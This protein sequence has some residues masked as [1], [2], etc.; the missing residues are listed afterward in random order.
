MARKKKTWTPKQGRWPS[1]AMASAYTAVTLRE[2]RHPRGKGIPS[3]LPATRPPV[4]SISDEDELVRHIKDLEIQGFC[5]GVQAV[6]KLAYEMA[7]HAGMKHRFR[8]TEAFG[9]S[10]WLVA[11]KARRSVSCKS[12]DAEPND[13]HRSFQQIRWCHGSCWSEVKPGSDI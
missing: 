8:G 6:C 10:S 2:T 7:E 4:F 5:T 1:D 13:H 3:S 9:T 12:N 11:E